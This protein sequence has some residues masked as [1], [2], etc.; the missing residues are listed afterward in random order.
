[1][2]EMTATIRSIDKS[3]AYFTGFGSYNILL[4]IIL[5]LTRVLNYLRFELTKRNM[6]HAGTSSNIIQDDSSGSQIS[7]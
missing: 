4:F 3:R 1:M 2:A 6:V 7:N 5:F